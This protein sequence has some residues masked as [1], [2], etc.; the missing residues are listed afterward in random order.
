[1]KSSPF[2]KRAHSRTASPHLAMLLNEIQ[3]ASDFGDS[4]QYEFLRILTPEF[5]KPSLDLLL[6]PY[7]A[8]SCAEFN[9]MAIKKYMVLF[10]KI[11]G[12]PHCPLKM[13]R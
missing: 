7:C 12:S 5:S 8:A 1:M 9:P 11:H 6:Q 10:L 13:D 2:L 4:F 3:I